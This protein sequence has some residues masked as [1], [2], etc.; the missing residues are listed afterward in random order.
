MMVEINTNPKQKPKK[1]KSSDFW[2]KAKKKPTAQVDATKLDAHTGSGDAFSR[3]QA[4]RQN[5]RGP[6]ERAGSIARDPLAARGRVSALGKYGQKAARFAKKAATTAA[7][8]GALNVSSPSISQSQDLP[9]AIFKDKIENKIEPKASNEKVAPQ[10]VVREN[11]DENTNKIIKASAEEVAKIS[12]KQNSPNSTLAVGNVSVVS[13]KNSA[14]GEKFTGREQHLDQNTTKDANII[15][16]KFSAPTSIDRAKQPMLA[17]STETNDLKYPKIPEKIAPLWNK[18]VP[19]NKLQYAIGKQLELFETGATSISAYNLLQQAY[20]SKT[21]ELVKRIV[22]TNKSYPNFLQKSYPVVIKKI[23][24]QAEFTGQKVFIHPDAF[25]SYGPDAFSAVV[26]H[27]IIGHGTQQ[28]KGQDFLKLNKGDLPPEFRTLSGR[29]LKEAMA[30][31]TNELYEYNLQQVD[32]DKIFHPLLQ[33]NEQG[34]Y[35]FLAGIKKLWQLVENNQNVFINLKSLQP[36]FDNPEG[37]YGKWFNKIIQS[38]AGLEILSDEQEKLGINLDSSAFGQNKE[39][40]SE[41]EKPAVINKPILS[42]FPKG[43]APR[44]AVSPKPKIDDQQKETPKTSQPPEADIKNQLAHAYRADQFQL[45]KDSGQHPSEP[46]ASPSALLGHKMD[47]VAKPTSGAHPLLVG[48]IKGAAPS[49]GRLGSILGRFNLPSASARAKQMG[50]ALPS[51]V[52]NQQVLASSSQSLGNR[53]MNRYSPG[54][55]EKLGKNLGGATG[56]LVGND[57]LDFAI[58]NALD[59]FERSVFNPSGVIGLAIPTFGLWP[60][61]VFL[62]GLFFRL[63]HGFETGW[64]MKKFKTAVKW[65]T[66]IGTAGAGSGVAAGAAEAGG[67]TLKASQAAGS[68]AQKS[69]GLSSVGTSR[70]F[71]QEITAGKT[72]STEQKIMDEL[73]NQRQQDQA[74]SAPPEQKSGQNPI[75]GIA[76]RFLQRKFRWSVSEMIASVFLSF[77]IVMIEIG[78]IALA[79]VLLSALADIG[80]D[81]AGAKDIFGFAKGLFTAA[82]KTI[83][84]ILLFGAPLFNLLKSIVLGII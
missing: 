73:Q 83:D 7:L 22:E 84:Y 54:W 27:E 55:Q 68:L 76:W 36:L 37:R 51:Q 82:A 44:P 77:L 23:K 47:S 70:S 5:L 30:Y 50:S 8:A 28:T 61:V 2:D 63:P 71:T 18:N 34:D 21:D 56:G 46:M 49:T 42:T 6:H 69:G 60:A 20:G 33:K 62:F 11:V 45:E 52:N 19:I 64:D 39:V 72:Q 66:I 14:N 48:D 79:L 25:K 10:V 81:L 74:Q 75:S 31:A 53:F 38:F 43:P 15:Y 32:P 35:D 40:K 29:S 65:G 4:A 80:S 13:E 12:N 16:P 59:N 58:D 78:I 24:S 57:D 17:L 9:E 41:T 3:A 26:A 67:T 1:K